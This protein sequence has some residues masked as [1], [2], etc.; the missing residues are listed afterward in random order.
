VLEL[1][2]IT[3]RFPGVVALKGVTLK[4]RPGEV[5]A[6][7]GENGSGKST[8]VK[9]ASGVLRP[10]AGEIR[11]RGKQIA[12]HSPHYAQSLGI[13]TI[14]QEFALAP[15]LTIG[16][17]VFLGREPRRGGLLR[18]AV[19]RREMYDRCAS[20]LAALS[21]D[22]D[23]RTRVNRL[24]VAH[25]QIVEI[26][27]AVSRAKESVLI[28]DEPTSA[29]STREA[30]ELFR[31]IRDARAA[32]VAI[33]YVSHR[34]EEIRELS[35]RVTVLRD[36][37]VVGN[38]EPTDYTIG[39]LIALMIG[40]DLADQYPQRKSAPQSEVLLDVRGLTVPGRVR[41]VSV[42]VKAGEIL[43][44]FGLVGAGRSE[45]VTALIGRLASR[46][47]RIAVQGR[48]F[49][50]GRVSAALRIGL[51]LVPEDRRSQGLLP[52]LSVA[53]NIVL[54]SLGKVASLGVLNRR[55]LAESALHY[56]K[57]LRI[58]T[59]SLSTEIYKL[60]G[61]NQ[62]KAI[63]ARLLHADAKVLLLD[64]PTRGIDVGAKREV[65]QLITDL[66][67]AGHS[68]VMISSELPELIGLCDRIAV[69]RRGRV[70]ADVR[71]QDFSAE[72]LLQHAMA[73]LE[74]EPEHLPP[75]ADAS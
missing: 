21:V 43:G 37:L 3:K 40:R 49:R 31:I 28:M 17:N 64:E 26:V 5:H 57:F 22:L 11:H 16:E 8:L 71:R 2:G 42:S 24:G 29:L 55:R 4:L 61:G 60:S 52:H 10:D 35:D 59:P 13:S 34:L 48:T 23:P 66:A 14:Y 9:V 7:V 36:A 25:R 6:L 63:L 70:V 30:R 69:M 72:V 33:L 39:S 56:V 18:F 67:D 1:H 58:R 74:S 51:G 68:V 62:Q 19:N 45:V 44:L 47:K 53:H 41:D 15:H 20:V 54:S 12:L 73:S 75:L 50:P 32:G 38:L 27:R 65:Y 46:S